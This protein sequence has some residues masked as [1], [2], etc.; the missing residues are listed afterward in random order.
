VFEATLPG[1]DRPWLVLRSIDGCYF[2]VVTRSG[3]LL[4]DVRRRFRDVR[5]S[6]EDA[7][8]YAEPGAPADGGGM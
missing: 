3:P 7:A 8:W 2:V 5:P 4:A 6:P 1:E